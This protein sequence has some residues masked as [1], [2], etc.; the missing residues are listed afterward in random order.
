MCISKKAVGVASQWV[1]GFGTENGL[2]FVFD[3]GDG[4]WD[5]EFVIDIVGATLERVQCYL[6]D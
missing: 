2:E 6:L 4:Y 1:D 3:G 5:F